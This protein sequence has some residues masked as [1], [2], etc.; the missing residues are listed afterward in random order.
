MRETEMK[1]I[2]IRI[3]NIVQTLAALNSAEPAGTINLHGGDF[4]LGV[5]AGETARHSG[6]REEEKNNNNRLKIQSR[7]LR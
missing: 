6:E 3:W 7:R 2:R 4:P 5:S 1:K